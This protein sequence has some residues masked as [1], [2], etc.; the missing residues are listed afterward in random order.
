MADLAL[1]LASTARRAGLIFALRRQDEL[2]LEQLDHLIHEGKYK[3]ELT[4][5]TVTD[6]LDRAPVP[7]PIYRV[8]E[9][10]TVEDA[11][12]RVF[13]THQTMWLSS[14]FFRRMFDLPRWTAQKI[15]VELAEAG[16]LERRGSTA[17]TRYRYPHHSLTL[18]LHARAGG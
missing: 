5:L 6:V 10:E 8:L 12:M 16:L 2:T 9:H 17:A 14:G 7:L 11:V 1:E 18:V 4:E 3:D 15:L 13:R